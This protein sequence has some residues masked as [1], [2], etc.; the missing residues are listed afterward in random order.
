MAVNDPRFDS[1]KQ[2]N[3]SCESI[4][5]EIS[6]SSEF[7]IGQH[8]VAID[9]VSGFSHGAFA[10]VVRAKYCGA[11]VRV[12]RIHAVLTEANRLDMFRFLQEC[13]LACDLRHPNIVHFYGIVMDGHLPMLVMEELVCSLHDFID[14]PENV[15]EYL[16]TPDFKR[17]TSDNSDINPPNHEIVNGAETADNSVGATGGQNETVSS[18]KPEQKYNIEPHQK[19]VIAL[20]IAQ[21]LAYLHTKKPYP[22]VHRDLSSSNILLG[23]FARM[24]VAKIADFGQSKE[25]KRK[26]DWS[27]RD[28][29]TLSYLPPE[30][31]TVQGGTDANLKAQPLLKTN[32]VRNHSHGHR[33]VGDA[34]PSIVHLIVQEP[35]DNAGTQK[36]SQ[37]TKSNPLLKTSIDMYMYGVLCLEI[38]SEQHPHT[39]RASA[40]ESWH[41]HHKI[42]LKTFPKNELLCIIAAHCIIEIPHMRAEAVN[43]VQFIGEQMSPSSKSTTPESNKV[44]TMLCRLV[45]QPE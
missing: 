22:I 7:I 45:V 25:I 36:S 9:R 8:R 38:F 6:V 31:L 27:S 16:Y 43:L 37:V 3:T 30:V 39:W 13:R 32:I 4:A 28:T 44:R 33:V 41:T 34:K 11:N 5:K 40:K 15:L 14:K 23:V 20:E 21:G 1:L 35:A 26:D 17:T 2:C 29:G 19:V 42:K 24:I 10:K 12:K 18:P